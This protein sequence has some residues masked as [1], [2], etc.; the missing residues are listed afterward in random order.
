MR[1]PSAKSGSIADRGGPP[2]SR[3]LQDARAPSSARLLAGSP[4]RRLR[5]EAPPPDLRLQS[6]NWTGRRLAFP[7]LPV[8][9]ARPTESRLLH[10]ARG[11]RPELSAARVHYIAS[12]CMRARR[13]IKRI[14]R[15]LKPSLRGFSAR[16]SAESRAQLAI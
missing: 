16:V 5:R 12:G 13:R 9:A 4:R 7:K 10:L 11:G 1:A 15:R 8:Y 2:V 14:S 3:R 6:A